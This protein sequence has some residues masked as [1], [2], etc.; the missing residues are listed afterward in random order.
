MKLKAHEK[1]AVNALEQ[2]LRMSKIRVT[3]RTL[4]DKLWQHPEFPSLASLSDTLDEL[5]VS[6]LS[7]R[8]TQ[9]QLV[10]V[11]L[12]AI[13]YLDIDGGIFAPIRSISKMKSN[14]Y[15]PKRGGISKTK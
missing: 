13:A 14:G 3:K 5:K 7:V 9:E 10:E 6:N 15:T 8:L 2:L 4:Q 11:P 12:P 1:N